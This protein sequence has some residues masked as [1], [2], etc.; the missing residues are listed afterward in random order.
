MQGTAGPVT[1]A[2]RVAGAQLPRGCYIAVCAWPAIPVLFLIWP[3]ARGQVAQHADGVLG[4]DAT[5]CLMACLG[6]TPLITIMRAKLAEFRLW[7][8]IWVFFLGAAALALHLAY[9][10]AAGIPLGQRAAGNVVDWTGLLIVALL[11]PMAV[12]SSAAAQKIL[13]P[14]WKRWQRSLMW[15]VWAVTG[16]HFL[17]MGAWLVLAAYGGATVPALLLRS[18]RVRRSVRK[19]RGGGYSTG[20]WWLALAVLGSITLAGF[21]IV[22]VSEAMALAG[23][24]TLT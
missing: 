20:G 3:A 22:A 15:T 16:I 5:L 10:P 6:I 11:L 8:G 4:F 7:F 17:L 9:P 12:T 23:A 24:V 1:A 21:V 14:E 18:G 19:W 2:F 13:G